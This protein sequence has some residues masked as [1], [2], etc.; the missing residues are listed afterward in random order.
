MSRAT[1]PIRVDVIVDGDATGGA[2]SLLEV[3]APAGATLPR[4]VQ[5]TDDAVL[6]VL[7]GE[8]ELVVDG[9][10][11]LLRRGAHAVLP[12]GVP[13]QVTVRTDARMLLMG[14][15]AGIERLATVLGDPPLGDDDVAALLAAA[16]V[17][18]LPAI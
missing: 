14:T 7:D 16:G 17:A 2:Y 10:P 5:R 9:M 4:H 1:T 3:R 8:V 12:H 15:P 11:T 13:R 6:H 18:L